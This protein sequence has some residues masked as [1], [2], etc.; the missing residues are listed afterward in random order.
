VM[1]PATMEGGYVERLE[2][3]GVKFAVEDL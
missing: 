3:A 1:T 2:R